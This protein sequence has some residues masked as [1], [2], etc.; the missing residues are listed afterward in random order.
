MIFQNNNLN[1]QIAIF[2]LLLLPLMSNSQTLNGIVIDSIS[3]EPLSFVHIGVEGKNVGLISNDKGEFS[4]D[5]SKIEAEDKIQFSII[6][7]ETFLLNSPKNTQEK[8]IVKLA[9]FSYKF[10]TV[11][12]EESRKTESV[13]LGRYSPSKT[14]T[15]QSGFKEFGFGGELGIK[16]TYPGKN[17]YLKEINFHTRFNTVDSVL[18][19]LNVYDVKD[20]LPG[21]SKLQKE[22]YVTS[23]AKDKW[24]TS[25]LLSHGLKIEEDIIVTFELVRIWYSPKGSNQLFYTHGKGYKEGKSFSRESSHD[26]WSVNKREPIAMYVTGILE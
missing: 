4:I 6:G 23:Y 10:Q 17:Y 25:N 20:N 13:K 15:G 7:Y 26:K 5:L 3:A 14:T 1:L 19:R 9:P 22:V 24:I 21:K 16:I 18:Y 12:V 2:S 8:L 11:I